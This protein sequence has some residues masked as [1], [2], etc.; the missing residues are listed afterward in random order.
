MEIET[1]QSADKCQNMF[2][3]MPVKQMGMALSF[4]GVVCLCGYV[5]IPPP[6]FARKGIVP[7]VFCFHV[8]VVLCNISYIEENTLGCSMLVDNRY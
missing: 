2:W 6:H 8:Q 4:G 5:V 3:Q 7:S 1:R